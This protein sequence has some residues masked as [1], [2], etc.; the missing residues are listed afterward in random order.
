MRF[1]ASIHA[2]TDFGNDAVPFH[3][4]LRQIRQAGYQQVMLLSLPGRPGL[5]S[6]ENPPCSLLD[7]SRSDP[8]AL[9]QALAEAGLR[10][11][12]MFGAGADFSTDEAA[13]A[14]LAWLSRLCDVAMALDCRFFGH[15]V[16]TAAAPNMPT[17]AKA[18]NILRL[19]R[20]MDALGERCAESLY[21][22]G[23]VHWHGNVETVADCEFLVN[24]L[25][26]PNTGPLLN[27][28][29]MTTC[30]QD[31]WTLLERYPE[32]IRFI[33]WKD[34]SLAPDRP[35]PVTSVELGTGDSPFER[36][37]PIVKAQAHVERVHT[38]ALETV[39]LAEKPAAMRR[40]LEY[41][42]GLWLNT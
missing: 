20:V 36:Y 13:D 18:E 34:H 38:I 8:D 1:A 30:G 16:G 5:H 22:S 6:G 3:E 41:M 40:S 14:A 25:A 42:A 2:F 35:H 11:S 10:L 26:T 29:H 7:H 32:R 23:D 28:G 37:I 4:A 21:I 24:Q 9:S 31:G 27:I 17:A 15:S 33:A 12:V 19:A 39:P